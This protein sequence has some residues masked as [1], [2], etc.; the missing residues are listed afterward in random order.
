HATMEFVFYA[1]EKGAENYNSKVYYVGSPTIPRNDAWDN[2]TYMSATRSIHFSKFTGFTEDDSL[3]FVY[4]T[5]ADAV[6]YS[7]PVFIPVT[8]DLLK[9]TSFSVY[10]PIATVYY[11]KRGGSKNGRITVT[12]DRTV[13][14]LS[15]GSSSVY[16]SRGYVGCP[17]VNTAYSTFPVEINESRRTTYHA[18]FSLFEVN[19]NGDFAIEQP[20]DAVVLTVNNDVTK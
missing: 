20:S 12:G 2:S 14:S 3:P 10:S 11:N 7:R 5:G 19:I 8:Y 17:S 6:S 13:S 18:M 1:V 15:T 4:T 9:D 16:R